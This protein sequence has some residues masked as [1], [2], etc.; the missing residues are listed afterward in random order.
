MPR[1]A[2]SAVGRVGW[3]NSKSIFTENPPKISQ[4]GAVKEKKAQ[5]RETIEKPRKNE[6][7]DA[8]GP[9]IFRAT[10]SAAGRVGRGNSKSIFTENPPKISQVE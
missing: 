9:P 7:L 2:G 1:A 8:S 6:G 3:G 10:G 4:V 5:E